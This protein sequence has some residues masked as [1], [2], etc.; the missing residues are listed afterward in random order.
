MFVV[1]GGTTEMIDK[2]INCNINCV[3]TINI[4]S[5]EYM[6]MKLLAKPI[7]RMCTNDKKKI[8]VLKMILLPLISKQMFQAVW[9]TVKADRLRP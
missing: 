6:T 3:G 9:Y 7:T 4:Q 1:L 5:F 8:G 2:V